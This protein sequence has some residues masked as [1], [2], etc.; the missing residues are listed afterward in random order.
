MLHIHKDQEKESESEDTEGL[1]APLPPQPG[2]LLP[3]PGP[4]EQEMHM[5]QLQ[6]MVVQGQAMHSGM[7]QEMDDDDDDEDDEELD[8]EEDDDLDEED[9]E[10]EPMDDDEDDEDEDEMLA[11]IAQKQ[12]ELIFVKQKEPNQPNQPIFVKQKGVLNKVQKKDVMEDEDDD[13]DESSDEE[14]L[15]PLDRVQRFELLLKKTEV[16]SHFNVAAPKEIPTSPLKVDPTNPG[17]PTKKDTAASEP[18]GARHRKS[19]KEE[20]AELLSETANGEMVSRFEFSPWFIKGGEMRDYQIRGLNWM[21]GLYD[22]GINGILADEMGLG[23][24]LQ[25]ISL[26]AYMKHYRNIPGPN[27][28]IVPKSTLRNWELEFEKWCP[29]MSSIVLIGDKDFRADF[30]KDVVM[31]GEWDVLIT[32]YEMVVAES[33]ALKKFSW[34]YMVIDEAHRIKNEESLLSQIVRKFRSK[35]RLLITGTPLQNNLHELWALLNFLLPKVFSSAAD[36]DAWFDTNSCLGDMTLIERLHTILRPFL[37]R[38]LKSE[39]EKGL[40]PKIECKLYIGITDMQ[41]E[42]YKKLL[43][44]D[45]DIVNGAG[46]K[47]KVRLQNIM[48]Q[49]RKCCNHPYLFDGIEPGPPYTTDYH[50][51]ENSGKMVLLDK[52]LPKLKEQGS[53]LLLFSQMTRMMDILEDYCLWRGYSYCRIDGQ[54]AHELR[55]TQIAEYNKPDSEKFLFMLSTR[56]GGLGINLATADV[57]IL[58]D[59]DWNPQMDLQAMDRAHRIGQKKQVRVFRFL[60]ENTIEEKLLERAEIKLRLDKLVVQQG[61]LQDSKMNKLGQDEM[62]NMIRHGAND[63]FKAEGTDITDED[64]DHILE[65]GQAKTKELN[66]RLEALGEDS[67]K[68]LTLDTNSSKSLYTFDG[69]DYKGKQKTFNIDDWIAPP[70]RER[71]QAAKKNDGKDHHDDDDDI[72]PSG[73]KKKRKRRDLINY[74]DFDSDYDGHGGKINFLKCDEFK[75]WLTRDDKGRYM[76]FVCRSVLKKLRHLSQFRLHAGGPRHKY[77]MERKAMGIEEPIVSET[78]WEEDEFKDWVVVEKR[79]G[80]LRCKFCDLQF[81]NKNIYQIRQHAAGPR[82]RTCLEKTLDPCELKELKPWLTRDENGEYHCMPCGKV[83]K[84]PE[85]KFYLMHAVKPRHIKAMSFYDESTPFPRLP[86]GNKD[87]R[88]SNWLLDDEF[89]PWLERD[90]SVP[91]EGENSTGVPGVDSTGVP[92]VEEGLMG[93]LRCKA[94]NKTIDCKTKGALRLHAAGIK[95]KKL[96]EQMLSGVIPPTKRTW[97]EEPEFLEW[98]DIVD[99]TPDG[100][101]VGEEGSETTNDGS[102]S[103]VNGNAS[104]SGMAPSQSGASA[105]DSLGQMAHGGMDSIMGASHM[106]PRSL[107]P[108]GLDPRADPR[109]LYPHGMSPYQM[110]QSHLDPRDIDP[111]GMDPRGMYPGSP[112][113]P[114]YMQPPAHMG[115]RGLFSPHS[116][117]PYHMGAS[118]LGAR[119]M[120]Y[121]PPH[122][123]DMDP[124]LPPPPPAHGMDPNQLGSGIMDLSGMG[125]NRM[126]PDHM[127]TN[128]MTPDHMADHMAT[129]RMTPDH[130]APNRMTPDHMA[131]STSIGSSH[132]G[133]IQMPPTSQMDPTHMPQLQ[134]GAGG[135]INSSLNESG[136]SNMNASGLNSSGMEIP[137]EGA[138]KSR[139]GFRCKPCNRVLDYKTKGQF[140]LHAAGTR[141]RQQIALMRGEPFEVVEKRTMS[142]EEEFGSWL[143]RD[144]INDTKGYIE[145][146]QAKKQQEQQQQPQQP[147]QQP[148]QPHQPHQHQP[149]QPLQQLHQQQN[150][151]QTLQQQHHHQQQQPYPGHVGTPGMHDGSNNMGGHSIGGHHDINPITAAAAMGHGSVIQFGGSTLGIPGMN[152]NPNPFGIQNF[153]GLNKP[154]LGVHGGLLPPH[155]GQPQPQ[156]PQPQPHIQLPTTS[157][158]AAQSLVGPGKIEGG[159]VEKDGIGGY[160]IVVYRCTICD[161][162]MDSKNKSQLRLHASSK[163][164]KMMLDVA[165]GIIPN[166]PETKPRTIVNKEEEF[167][168]WIAVNE[169]VGVNGEIVKSYSCRACN[170]SLDSYK[171]TA[172]FR[173]HAATKKHIMLLDTMNGVE[174]R[175]QV[176][177]RKNPFDE[178]S[179]WLVKMEDLG[180]NF[181]IEFDASNDGMADEDSNGI[182][183]DGT[184]TLNLDA[185][186]AMLDASG[187]ALDREGSVGVDSEGSGSND[188]GSRAFCKI[189]NKSI[190][191]KST[192]QLRQHANTKRHRLLAGLPEN[193][194]DE[195]HSQ[196]PEFSYWL[197]RD[198]EYYYCRP[199]RKTL[200]STKK[201]QFRQHAISQ[202]HRMRMEY[203]KNHPDELKEDAETSLAEMNKE[204]FNVSTS[205]T[206]HYRMRGVKRNWS[207]DPEFRK[208]LGMAAN[209]SYVCR[210]CKKTLDCLKRHQFRSHSLSQKHQILTE[211]F[212]KEHPEIANLPDDVDGSPIKGPDGNKRDWCKDPEFSDWLIKDDRGN[213]RCKP[214]NKVMEHH[215]R[216]KFISHANGQKHKLRLQSMLD[217]MELEGKYIKREDNADEDEDEDEDEDDS[218]MEAALTVKVEL[219]E[220]PPPTETK[221][222]PLPA[223]TKSSP[224]PGEAKNSSLPGEAKSTSAD[225]KSDDTPLL[226]NIKIEPSDADQPPIHSTPAKIVNFATTKTKMVHFGNTEETVTPVKSVNFDNTLLEKNVKFEIGTDNNFSAKYVKFDTTPV[227]SVSYESSIAHSPA[228]HS[229]VP[230]IAPAHITPAK[231]VSFESGPVH[232]PIAHSPA[233]PSP[234]APSPMAPSPMAPSP[235]AHSPMA[236]SPMAHSPM[237][238]SPMAP[239]RMVPSP[240][241][242]SPMAPSPIAHSGPAHITPHKTVSYDSP[243]DSP[244]A[245]YSSVPHSPIAYSVASDIGHAHSGPLHFSVSHSGPTDLAPV[246]SPLPLHMSA[247]HSVPLHL[248]AA[249]SGAKDYSPVNSPLPAHMSAPTDYAPVSSPHSAQVSAPLDHVPVSSP[250][251]LHLSS[252]HDLA[253][254]SSPHTDSAT[255]TYST[256]EHTIQT[257]GAPTYSHA[258][259]G[260]PPPFG[261]SPFGVSPFAASPYGVPPYGA[262]PPFPPSPYAAPPYPPYTSADYSAPPFSGPPHTDPS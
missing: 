251:A 147:Q 245:D 61:R 115:S 144:V 89:A 172:Q 233:A 51:V 230:H 72:G 181:K 88:E 96:Y 184:L 69:E 152:P 17:L 145:Q 103:G 212:L 105:M 177:P 260:A 211:E 191:A 160:H 35:N 90:D 104:T 262:P 143:M 84:T 10:G 13:D 34:K 186:S 194:S 217:D 178:F 92:V 112:H 137:A 183:E 234:M 117:S 26:L 25:T 131:P 151:Q 38:R 16:Y 187:N 207:E 48:M 12:Q 142:L 111:R 33:T 203:L 30:I 31:P 229:P 208:W 73:P 198:G 153:L 185:G 40:L 204:V 130:M 1:P 46:S 54:T 224:L 238:H 108:R 141:H 120:L 52:L 241:P 99:L 116:Y 70:K 158:A 206:P 219:G 7:S 136:I 66:K 248:S 221:S 27:L 199:C 3:Q 59:S 222:N 195:D 128:R 42:M 170:K 85:L 86:Q 15:P 174:P 121:P 214:C 154:E 254:V 213:Y 155:L 218:M 164:H 49:L 179:D 107:D 252:V 37:L 21:I 196:D 43:M 161:K 5:F 109:A 163:R 180:G 134:Q 77:M 210:P 257:L 243:Y 122:G 124:N 106:D 182:D 6:P 74:A 98:I 39:V 247:P 87:R 237:A 250:H 100:K 53:R 129:N 4:M 256:A 47:E 24:T 19:E 259:Y 101:V 239:N 67:L 20:D 82:H 190:E 175:V 76:C 220:D 166:I 168:E 44:K 132:L 231:S 22:T 97:Y 249:H 159:Q 45:I 258:S 176:T 28:I 135:P 83:F 32:S 64:I 227:K 60:Q 192:F 244:A 65:R 149:Q 23:K 78:F 140:R 14:E 223:E 165:K 75:D 133:A 205:Y 253:P 102:S 228:A 91:P 29:S 209:G 189:C 119:D 56:A 18:G 81:Q 63:V 146:Q 57:V 156:Q 114:P 95:H 215:K 80:K 171:T 138:P 110:P 139:K 148:Q 2:L 41:R 216:N 188:T 113:L 167:A 202:K 36:F 255:I 200:D 118:H 235:M 68:G 150:Q 55:H 236:H 11:Q 71:R 242:R 126:T 169:S 94:C 226:T 127:A 125:P 58:Y 232:S 157:S 62:L 123:M 79:G 8:E 193:T 261:A 246:S 9:L 173:I 93:G 240:M 197:T 225:D 201:I 162:I 50:L